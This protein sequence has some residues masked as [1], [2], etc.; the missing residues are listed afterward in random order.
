MGQAQRERRGKISCAIKT[1]VLVVDDEPSIMRTVCMILEAYGF[2]TQGASSGD[3][4]ITQA[5]NSCPDLLL[6]DVMMPGK[7]GF[8]TALEIKK[9][10]PECRLLFFTGYASQIASLTVTLT[11]NGY[12]FD[13]LSKPML[14]KELLDSVKAALAH[15]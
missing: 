11:S 8:E 2:D 13:L 3:E 15:A 9:L 6:S 7:N 10:C 5:A 4:A 1:R 12:R 14:P